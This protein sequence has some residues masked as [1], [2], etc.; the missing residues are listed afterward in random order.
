MAAM[1]ADIADAVVTALN[2]ATLSQTF[3]AERSY[4]PLH[5]LKDL[6]DLKVTVV[7]T[8]LTLSSLTR[9]G[10]SLYDYV[11]DI[12]VQKSLGSGAMTNAQIVAAA[13]PYMRLSQEI[14]DLFNSERIQIPYGPSVNCITVTNTPIFAAKHIDEMRLFTSVISL[15][16]RLGR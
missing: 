3:T 6:A 2:N 12:G 16:F 1:I 5:E 9:A 4:V 10:L 13:D 15:T 11:I 7:P 8:G 14:V